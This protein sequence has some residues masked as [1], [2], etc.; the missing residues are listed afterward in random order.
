MSKYNRKPSKLTIKKLKEAKK[1]I[2]EHDIPTN[3]RMIYLD[4]KILRS[5]E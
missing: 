4:G 5:E 1:M 3:N 2:D